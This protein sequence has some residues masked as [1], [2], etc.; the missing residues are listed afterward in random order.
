MVASDGSVFERTGTNAECC[1]TYSI[2]MSED[3]TSYRWPLVGLSG[4][5]A[6]GELRTYQEWL[7]YASELNV[8]IC[9]E[10]WRYYK[11]GTLFKSA[12]KLC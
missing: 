8:P 5:C 3:G 11:T 6:G 12:F 7:D 2:S 10:A 1:L 4:D 9:F